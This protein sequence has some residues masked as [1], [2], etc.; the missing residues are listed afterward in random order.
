VHPNRLEPVGTFRQVSGPS[1]PENRMGQQQQG[2]L[3][4]LPGEYIL[5]INP[6]CSYIFYNSWYYLLYYLLYFL[7]LFAAFA[8]VGYPLKW[9][10]WEP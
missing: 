4:D 2:D 5:L 9:Q 7:C 3:R 6:I 10:G 8:Y 1:S